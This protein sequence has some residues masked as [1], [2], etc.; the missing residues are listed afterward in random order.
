MLS[1]ND[2]GS[3]LLLISTGKPL[4]I[5]CLAIA[6]PMLPAPIIPINSCNFVD[7]SK[8]TAQTNITMVENSSLR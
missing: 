5:K 1:A 8:M 6:L 7:K 4:F 2:A 3:L